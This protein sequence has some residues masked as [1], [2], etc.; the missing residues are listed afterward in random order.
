MGFS[1]IVPTMWK[2]E[3]FLG[4]LKDLVNE[5][6]VREIIIINNDRDKTPNDPI[7]QH[8]KIGLYWFNEGNI[9]VNPAWNFGVRNSNED[10][11]CLM[12]DDIIFDTKIFSRLFDKLDESSGVYG[13]CPGDPIHNQPPVT[14]GLIDLIQT[15]VPYHY[16]T[17]FG[18]GQLMFLH[19]SNWTPIPDGLKIYWGDNFVYDTHYHKLNNNHIIT[20]MFFHT[21]CAVT[22]STIIDAGEILSRENIVYNQVMPGIVEDI[23]S[24]K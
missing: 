7:L 4:F 22:T 1:V 13:L 17:H 18:F 16:S 12:N 6:L 3:P 5:Y 10:L 11:I 20:N 2:Y 15:P 19:K 23:L 14:N 8:K 24:K 9:G 21:P